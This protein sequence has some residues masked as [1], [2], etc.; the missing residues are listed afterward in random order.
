MTKLLTGIIPAILTPFDAEGVVN[1]EIAR[2]LVEF[3]LA[4]GAS[5]FYVCGGA[6][7]GVLLT[8]AERRLMA[9]TIIDQVKGRVPVIIHVGAI[10]TAEAA[11]LA[12]HAKQVGADGFSSVPPFYFR[13][14]FQGIKR[15]YAELA[16]ASDLPMYVYNTPSAT[17]VNVTPAMF[18][19]MCEEIPTIAGIK[20]CPYNLFEMRQILDLEIR[21]QQPNVLTGPDELMVAAQAMGAHGGIGLSYNLLTKLFVDAYGAFHAGEVK[22]ATELQAKANRVIVVLLSL[23][24]GAVPTLKEMMKMIGFDCGSGRPPNPPVTEEQLEQLKAD[25][26]EAGFWNVVVTR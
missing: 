21:G 26:E 15:H 10:T 8:E 11:R 7:E 12:A 25:L 20:Y 13:V 6:G 3:Q 9:E 17:G 18:K 1:T 2:E 14:G 4:Q 19:E 16:R 23:G 22:K 24:I 5:G